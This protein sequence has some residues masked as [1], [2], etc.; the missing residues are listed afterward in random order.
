MRRAVLAYS[1]ANRR[2]KA[3]AI[4]RFMAD[5]QVESVLLCGAVGSGTQ[6]NESIIERV[7]GQ[8]AKLVVAFDVVEVGPQPWPFVVCDGRRM[9]FDTQT[10]DML[11]SNAVIEHVG[12]IEEQQQFVAEHARVA[13]AW[14]ITTP[15]KWFPIESHTSAIFRHWSS[16]WR[17]SRTEFTRLLSR[18]EFA[19]LLPVQTKIIGHWW[20]PTFSAY[21][22]PAR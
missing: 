9:P 4:Q 5:R 8:A 12:D 15:N 17:E 19:A 18:R 11:I 2:R 22:V 6:R 3:I 21:Y 16:S 20:S 7:A 14:V 10:F 13:R 1:V